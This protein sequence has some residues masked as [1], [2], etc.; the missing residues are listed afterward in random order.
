MFKHKMSLSEQSAADKNSCFRYLLLGFLNKTLTPPE[1]YWNTRFSKAGFPGI[2]CRRKR[3][4]EGFRAPIISIL[5]YFLNLS[6]FF[7]YPFF[8]GCLF[9][10]YSFA[11]KFFFCDRKILKQDRINTVRLTHIAVTELIFKPA[12]EKGY[13][14][15]GLDD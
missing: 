6:N 8:F 14:K 10:F 1:L 2:Q 13:K 5:I 4:R 9:C 3:V 11:R 15:V 12:G 7:S